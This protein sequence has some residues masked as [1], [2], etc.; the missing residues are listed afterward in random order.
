MSVL[1]AHFEEQTDVQGA[2]QREAPRH[3]SALQLR[4]RV[5]IDE[6]DESSCKEVQSLF[7]VTPRET[8][9]S[10]DCCRNHVARTDTVFS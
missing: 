7:R 6:S 4:E 8:R 9:S 1:L 5:W 10:R 2:R 3:R